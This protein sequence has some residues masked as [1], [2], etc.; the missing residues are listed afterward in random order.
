LE[1]RRVVSALLGVG[2]VVAGGLLPLWVARMALVSRE[3]V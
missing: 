3:E 1:E 2:W